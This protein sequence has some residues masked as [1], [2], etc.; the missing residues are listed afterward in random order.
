MAI[1][2]ITVSVTIAKI[3][4]AEGIRLR[5]KLQSQLQRDLAQH[6][7]MSTLLDPSIAKIIAISHEHFFLNFLS[8][9]RWSSL[10]VAEVC[11]R[12]HRLEIFIDLR[13]RL[14]IELVA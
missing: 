2:A 9:L 8:D 3:L 5:L 4:G 11:V 7:E 10:L 6:L 14:G 13:L 1:G 12:I